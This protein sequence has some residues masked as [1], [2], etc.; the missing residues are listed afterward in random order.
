MPAAQDAI[1]SPVIQEAAM[2]PTPKDGDETTLR[3]LNPDPFTRGFAEGLSP[4]SMSRVRIMPAFDADVAVYRLGGAQVEVSGLEQ[5][6]AKDLEA[7]GYAKGC[8]LRR[9]LP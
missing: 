1:T 3:P 8:E 7:L 2:I 5:I 9:K 6:A 4:I